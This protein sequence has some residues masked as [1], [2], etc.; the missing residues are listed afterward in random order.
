M[1][2]PLKVFTQ[3]PLTRYYPRGTNS[4]LPSIL[5]N[6]S[7]FRNPSH[8]FL[9]LSTHLSLEL[10]GLEQSGGAFMSVAC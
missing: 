8:M 10:V 1:P 7:V 5:E 6:N 4:V 2:L 3:S 9:E